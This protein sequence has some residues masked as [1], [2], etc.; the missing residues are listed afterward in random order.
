MPVPRT[1][2]IDDGGRSTV[3]IAPD[4]AGMTR[5]II[6]WLDADRLQRQLLQPLVEKYFGAGD[7]SEYVVAIVK[8]D[9]PS[10]VVYS[11][12]AGAAI[13][14]KNADVTTGLFDVRMDEVN[15]IAAGM[16]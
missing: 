12:T 5:A 9:D 6:V 11:S 10:R 4:P 7:A 14:E 1:N 3:T 13:D 16:G 2:R 8:R 15:R